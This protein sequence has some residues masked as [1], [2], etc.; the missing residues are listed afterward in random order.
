LRVEK[1]ELKLVPQ[2]EFGLFSWGQR[3]SKTAID[4]FGWNYEDIIIEFGDMTSKNT[5]F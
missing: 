4:F 5:V 1:I 2:M 3:E